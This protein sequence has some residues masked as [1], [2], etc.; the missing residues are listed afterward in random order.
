MTARFPHHYHVVENTPGYLPDS[1][2]ATFTSRRDA[3]SYALSLARE[4]RSDGYHVSGTRET[5]YYA[6]RDSSDLGRVI[7]ISD[8]YESD[9]GEEEA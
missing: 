8:C 1:E 7:E 9:C 5:G 6:E 4:L 2:P 3:G